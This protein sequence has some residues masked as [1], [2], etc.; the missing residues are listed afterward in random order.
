ME[1]GLVEDGL[2][3]DGLV[4]VGLVEYFLLLCLGLPLMLRRFPFR[5]DTPPSFDGL[6]LEPML[7]PKVLVV[8]GI[9]FVL[10][11][12]V[13]N[14]FDNPFHFLSES[15]QDLSV[16][17]CSTPI[18]V[19]YWCVKVTSNIDEIL[20]QQTVLIRFNT[21]YSTVFEYIC[22]FRL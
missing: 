9:N 11:D 8:K 21:R 17:P 12:F 5:V 13:A 22:S 6:S 1:D 2:V 4:E 10:C 20:H 15:I 14:I 7:I 18:L 3:E 19:D 16:G